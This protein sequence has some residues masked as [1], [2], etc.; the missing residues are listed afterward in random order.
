MTLQ[1]LNHHADLREKLRKAEA[2]VYRLQT[3]AHPGAQVLTGMPHTPGVKDLVGDLAIEIAEAQ[4]VVDEL[5]AQIKA[6]EPSVRSFIRTIDDAELR[7]IFRLR[8]IRGL[9]WK[10]IPEYIDEYAT[11]SSVSSVV[12]S[13]MRK[14]D[15]TAYD[16]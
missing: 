12:Y 16:I 14:H 15:N 4:E 2:L 6:E 11:K 7:T 5:D 1:Q 13:Y 9:S 10:E 3:K 8:F